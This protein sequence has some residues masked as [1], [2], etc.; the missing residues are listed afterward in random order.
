MRR[1][2]GRLVRGIVGAAVLVAV[3][4]GDR[5]PAAR[6]QTAPPPTTEACFHAA[7]TA[8]PL[9]KERKLRAAQRHLEVCAREE[10]PRAVRNDCRNWLD[11]V[12]RSIPTV[13]FAAREERADG[14]SRA[15]D[16]VRVSVD[17]EPLASRLDPSPVA[18]DPGVHTL[19]FEHAGFDP[20][21]QRIDVREGESR[22]EVDVVFRARPAAPSSASAPTS[23]ETPA[24]PPPGPH[25]EE[26]PPPAPDEGGHPVPASVYVLAGLGAVSLGAGLYMEALGLSDRAHLVNTCQ[27]TRSCAQSDVDSAH[28]EVLTGDILL[29]A[30]ALLVAGAAYVYF[31]S[32]PAA[33]NPSAITRLRLGPVGVRGLGVG[34]EG[35]L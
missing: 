25:E 30:S 13:V 9:M 27:T 18:L 12:K 28:R 32:Q 5:E 33:P 20:V 1:Q 34:I 29:G 22:R 11:D 23:P 14:T 8:Q 17:G 15:T 10:C 3:A 16:D 26:S 24:G 31:N 2:G 19:R 21:E 6:A 7:E 4:A 35:S